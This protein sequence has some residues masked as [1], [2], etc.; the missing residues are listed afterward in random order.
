MSLGICPWLTISNGSLL[1]YFYKY[2]NRF[3]HSLIWIKAKVIIYME[4]DL[5]E[6]QYNGFTY[7]HL[8]FWRKNINP[9]QLCQWDFT[10]W[11]WSFAAMETGNA[12]SDTAHTNGFILTLRVTHQKILQINALVLHREY[13]HVMYIKPLLFEGGFVHLFTLKATLMKNV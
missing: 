9:Y 13:S 2:K 10:V 11:D 12:W 6:K 1:H 4:G 5:W 8:H 3:H 7:G